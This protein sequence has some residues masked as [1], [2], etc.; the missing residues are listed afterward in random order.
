MTAISA[1]ISV[2]APGKIR[3]RVLWTLQ[4]LLGVFFIVASGLPKLVGQSDAVRVFDEIGWGDWFRY[5]TGLVELAGGIGLLVP[6]LS[7]LAAAG[8]S[9]TM[10]CAAATQAF[11]MDAP[12]MVPFPLILAVI[13][14]WIASER[15]VRVTR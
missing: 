11:L 15:G 2:K 7:G 10:V 1:T 12:A 5:L 3:S 13:F 6:R 9:I 8:L 4:I 14:A